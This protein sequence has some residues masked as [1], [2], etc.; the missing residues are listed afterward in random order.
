MADY[1]GNKAVD[2]S[3]FFEWTANDGTGARVDMSGTP[4]QADFQVFKDGSLM[5]L[6][7]SSI[8]VTKIGSTTGSYLVEVDTSVD[9]DFTGGSHYQVLFYPDETVDSIAI[10]AWL[11]SFDLENIF[12]YAPATV[13]LNMG[14]TIPGSPTTNTTGDALRQAT[15]EIAPK[16][17]TALNNIPVY[18][19]DS[20]TKEPATGLTLT[21][22]V[23][24]DGGTW[25]T[26]TGTVA[27]DGYGV[28]H[29]DASSADMDA[30]TVV[31]R[32][33]EASAE[34]A[35]VAMSTVV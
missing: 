23:L 12:N 34:P 2:S 14:Q 7:A 31:F 24:K 5:T 10:A 19:I 9:A 16:K 29:F 28:Y 3:V 15:L 30:N 18:M 6:D 35:V 27:E 1:K 4:T 22:E 21:V 20:S 25:A 17:A 33:T 13:D 8:L 11:G 26:P 32:F